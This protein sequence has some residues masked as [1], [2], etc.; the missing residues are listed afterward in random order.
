V[1]ERVLLT[2]CVNSGCS[3]W[4]LFETKTASGA[5]LLREQL[6]APPLDINVIEARLEAVTELLSDEAT[7]VALE[8]LVRNVG[9][10]ER[11]CGQVG[12]CV[13]LPVT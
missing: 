10:L 12:V 8:A 4:A 5:R 11:L 9:D 13:P 1:S 6:L 2:A 7:F 3:V